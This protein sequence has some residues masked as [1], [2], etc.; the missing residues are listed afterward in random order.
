MYIVL[1]VSEKMRF[2]SQCL[3][4]QSVYSFKNEKPTNVLAR[5]NDFLVK[6][7]L[8]LKSITLY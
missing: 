6:P 1:S 2:C 7:K 3:L 8:I 4:G 5:H